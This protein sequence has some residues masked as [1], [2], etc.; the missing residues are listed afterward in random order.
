[1]HKN[2]N[3]IDL[4]F[5]TLVLASDAISNPGTHVLYLRTQRRSVYSCDDGY[6]KTLCSYERDSL[7]VVKWRAG[8]PFRMHSRYAFDITGD[9]FF[10]TPMVQAQVADKN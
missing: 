3:R 8:E 1:M 5:L 6:S 4:S 10:R 2:R 7:Q 9:R